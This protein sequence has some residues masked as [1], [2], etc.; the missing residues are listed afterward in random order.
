MRI[1]PWYPKPSSMKPSNPNLQRKETR[2]KIGNIQ[3]K[4]KEAREFEVHHVIL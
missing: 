4:G 2:I 1:K 3:I